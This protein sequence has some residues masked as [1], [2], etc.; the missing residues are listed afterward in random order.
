MSMTSQEQ[1]PRTGVAPDAPIPVTFARGDGIGPEIMD[2]TLRVLEAAD[3]NLALEEIEIGQKVYERGVSAGI[4]PS[5]WES[6]RRTG[7]FF[8]APITTPQG[9]GF[10]SLNVTTRKSLGLYANVRPCRSYHPFTRSLHPG[11]NVVIVREN[12]EDTYAGIEHRQTQ[13]V[14]QCLKLISRPGSERVIRF[15][16]DYAVRSGRKKITCMTKDNIMKIT[17]GLFHRIFDDVAKEYPQIE[18][19]H[20]IIDIG[21]ALMAESPERFDVVITPNLYGDILSDIAAQVAGSVGLAGS[22]NIGESC[23]MFEAIHGSAPPIAGKNVANPS[24][25]L[26]A[27]VMMLVHVGRAQVAERIRNAWLSTIEDGIR[28]ADIQVMGADEPIVG[29]KEFAD[30][31]VERLGREPR[32]TTAA[33]YRDDP[34]V[35]PK[36][37]AKEEKQLVGVDVFLDWDEE[38]RDPEALG[39]RVTALNGDGLGLKMITNRGVKVYPD[40]LPETYCTD[41][42]RCRFVGST[43]GGSGKPGPVDKN[44]VLALL[45]R[46]HDAG[47]DYVKTEHLYTFDGTPGY[48]LG[49]S[50]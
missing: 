44:Q 22:A 45:G 33:H 39:R 24:G 4:E 13:E 34:N 29:T 6:L 49:Q 3:A 9:K 8:K 31:V 10:K 1:D 50:E 46:V 2:A 35:T 41:H 38:G 20:M 7:V 17:D 21:S 43:E 30:A 32:N 16:F 28:T 14:T 40:G 12:E 19:E 26:H 37:V 18:A 27:A 48:S 25:L 42:W 23:A 11:M 36:P 5:S 15:G 47:L